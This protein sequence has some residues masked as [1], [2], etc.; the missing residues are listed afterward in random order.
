MK[1]NVKALRCDHR[2]REQHGKQLS[3]REKRK[4]MEILKETTHGYNFQAQ[5]MSNS[6]Q[7]L[8]PWTLVSSVTTPIHRSP[9]KPFSWLY[10]R[11]ET[12]YREPEPTD[13][14]IHAWLN[15]GSTDSQLTQLIYTRWYQWNPSPNQGCL[16][17]NCCWCIGWKTPSSHHRCLSL[18]DE[19]KPTTLSSFWWCAEAVVSPGEM[20]GVVSILGKKY[21]L[22]AQNLRGVSAWG[23]WFGSLKVGMSYSLKWR[24]VFW[25]FER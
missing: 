13:S 9:L 21:L 6:C 3:I 14:L 12:A 19:R 8:C 16:Q 11:P 10:Y 22:G 20:S 2:T 18:G 17:D 7:T 5:M 23:L 4:E 24:G 15:Y 25:E 1:T